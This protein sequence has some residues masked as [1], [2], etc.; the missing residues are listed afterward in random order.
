MSEKD[1]HTT[2]MTLNYILVM[3]RHMEGAVTDLNS[4]EIIRNL[5]EIMCIIIVGGSEQTL[6]H[7]NI[8]TMFTVFAGSALYTHT[9]VGAW[10]V[11]T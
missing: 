8:L 6:R 2:L 11:D 10:R 5:N 7:T 3:Q 9:E 1:N 4:K